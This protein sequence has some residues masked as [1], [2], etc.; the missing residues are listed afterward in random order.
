MFAQF[1]LQ[2]FTATSGDPVP[3]APPDNGLLDSE[4]TQ[5]LQVSF[6]ALLQPEPLH[7]DFLPAGGNDLPQPQISVASDLPLP[8]GFELL[9]E[10]AIGPETADSLSAVYGAWTT[11]PAQPTASVAPTSTEAT[12]LQ[13][14]AI[15]L[16]AASYT[17]A[18]DRP[19]AEGASLRQ[20]P[21]LPD[22]NLA[23]LQPVAVAPVQTAQIP[24]AAT[25]GKRTS[26]RQLLPSLRLL[27]VD[28]Q[29]AKASSERPISTDVAASSSTTTVVTTSRGPE[30]APL[31]TGLS[32]L[33][34]VE[35]PTADP[36]AARM[37]E[38]PAAAQ[39]PSPSSV[40]STPAAPAELPSAP[41]SPNNSTANALLSDS[42]LPAGAL[43]I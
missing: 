12:R 42:R 8:D 37:A 17:V 4:T 24:Q 26:E 6:A 7:G 20:A 15:E 29:S 22:T 10:T 11:P 21:P 35:Q 1:N 32:R 14:P 13:A 39:A 2:L 9:P 31:A 36:L 41:P 25:T 33:Q 23:K 3:Q 5:E 30:I 43:P 38:R 18:P 19:G 27:D 40:L 34:T 28:L 16:S